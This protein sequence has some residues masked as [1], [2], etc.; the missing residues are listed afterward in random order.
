MSGHSCNL[1]RVLLGS[2]RLDLAL[3]T[4]AGTRGE[5]KTQVWEVEIRKLSDEKKKQKKKQNIDGIETHAHSFNG[6]VQPTLVHRDTAAELHL[7]HT[8]NIQLILAF[9][10]S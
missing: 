8:F 3:L 10:V 1:L 4:N 7:N 2:G 5:T 9:P 6:P